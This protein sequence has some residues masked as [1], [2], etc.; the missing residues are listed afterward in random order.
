MAEFHLNPTLTQPCPGCQIPLQ[1]PVTPGQQVLKCDHCG[2]TMGFQ[3]PRE[4]CQ[5][6]LNLCREMEQKI[7]NLV[8]FQPGGENRSAEP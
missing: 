3:I 5:R 8:S 7:S 1:I 4:P 6:I 2:A